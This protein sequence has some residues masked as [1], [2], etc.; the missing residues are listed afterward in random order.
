M[1]G[2]SW[3]L[4]C[5][6]VGVMASSAGAATATFA[7]G[8]FWCMEPPFEHVPGVEKVVSGYAG[9]PEPNPTYEQVSS[10]T[11]GHVEAVQIT[12]DPARV[13]YERLLDIFWREIDP[14]DDGGQFVDRGPQY[15]TVVFVH[16]DAQRTAAET[17]KAA[18]AASGRIKA[19]IVT[20]IVPFTTFYPAE[21]YHQNF[22]EKSPVRYRSYKSGSGRE[23]FKEQTWKTDDKAG[24]APAPAAASAAATPAGAPSGTWTKPSEAE[25][26]RRLTPLQYEV[27]QESATEPAFRNDFWNEKREG[28]YVDVVSGEPLFS[29]RD[30]YDSGT[31]WPSFTRP[32]DGA[33][34][35]EHEDAGFFSVRTEVRS[36]IADSHLGH[37][38]DDGPAPTGRRYCMNSAA[39]RFVPK[40][41]LEAEG[42]GKYLPLFDD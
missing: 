36:R 10:G 11:T 19:P 34:V 3:G 30:K 18:L 4:V 15:R 41:R 20:R 9:G 26:Q 38:F 35:T 23:Q 42:Y 6:F 7:G 17:S 16:D 8:C 12:Y 13:T 1:R 25:L 39:L 37:V 33:H 32:L 27:T 40:E 28:L 24:A 2:I 31:G 29:S 21:E 22:D 5:G 14:T